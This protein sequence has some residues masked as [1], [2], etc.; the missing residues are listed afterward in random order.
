LV[1]AAGI[2]VYSPRYKVAALGNI[3]TA[4][5]FR[6]QGIG[7]TL[8]SMLYEDLLA[9]GIV[10]VGL[11]VDSKNTGAFKIFLGTCRSSEW[12]P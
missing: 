10:A 1:S 12:A 5:E 11:N 7:T 4:P 3:A 2:H 6:G 8:V 9:D